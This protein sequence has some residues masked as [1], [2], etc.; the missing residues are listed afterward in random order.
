MIAL[1]RLAG[2]IVPLAV[3]GVLCS[4]AVAGGQVAW[5]VAGWS[6]AMAPPPGPA[7]PALPVAAPP[8]DIG[9]ILDLSPFGAVAVAAPVAPVTETTLDLVLRGV[10]LGTD[11]ATSLAQI[12]RQ[13]ETA[14]Y[15]PG[16]AVTGTARLVSVAVDHVV[17]DVG[18]QM[19]TLSFPET[20]LDLAAPAAPSVAQAGLD[21]LRDVLAAQAANPP[22]PRPEPPPA[23][24]PVTTQDQIALWRQRI[25]ANP[26]EVLDA[27][28][29][30]ATPDGYMIAEDHDSGVALAGL[31]PGDLV[32]SVNGQAVGN[33]DRDRHL[34]D[35]VAAS[36]QARIEVMRDGRMIV[37][38]F[39]LE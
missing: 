25:I 23:A 27:I 29:L 3:L 30:I 5:H 38:S 10:L 24:D 15:A 28:G 33:V 14:N 17:L 6:A 7:A 22:P 4:L 37:M 35:E 12:A 39:P 1:P 34:Y 18:G 2:P 19:Q 8:P 21:R 26:S 31:R 36:G 32:R 16:D 9:P 20:G 13:G 11:P